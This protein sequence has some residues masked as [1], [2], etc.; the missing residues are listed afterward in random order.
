MTSEDITIRNKILEL[1]NTIKRYTIARE[2]DIQGTIEKLDAHYK[3]RE[4]DIRSLLSILTTRI[5][6]IETNEREIVLNS[7]TMLNF[8][9][10]YINNQKSKFKT[11]IANLQENHTKLN[12]EIDKYNLCIKNIKILE[13]SLD[14]P[15]M[16]PVLRDYLV[17]D[18]ERLKNN[19]NIDIEKLRSDVNEIR[20]RIN[21]ITN[22]LSKIDYITLH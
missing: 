3:K 22:K 12:N 17:A 4:E 16:S 11:E 1:E 9:D 18:L 2:K 20:E 8:F 14:K 13:S 6:K 19:S 7:D 5:D 15:D 10:K 21:N